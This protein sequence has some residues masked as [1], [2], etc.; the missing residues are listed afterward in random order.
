MPLFVAVGLLLSVLR[1]GTESTVLLLQPLHSPGQVLD[2]SGFGGQ[3]LVQAHEPESESSLGL[4]LVLT[5]TGV[6]LERDHMILNK[7]TLK[8]ILDLVKLL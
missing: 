1:T 5:G 2:S 3:F 7:V 6:R 8:N 4:T